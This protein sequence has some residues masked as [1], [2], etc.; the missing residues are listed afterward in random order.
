MKNLQIAWNYKSLG[1][2]LTSKTNVETNPII[3]KDRIF[4]PSVDHHLLSINAKC[5]V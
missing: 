4:V 3:V 2:E 5:N 1:Q